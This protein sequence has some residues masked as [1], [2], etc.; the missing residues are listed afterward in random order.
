MATLKTASG[1]I[2][3]SSA[4]VERQAERMFKLSEPRRAHRLEKAKAL[5]ASKAGAEAKDGAGAKGKGGKG[6]GAKGKKKPAKKA[7]ATSVSPAARQAAAIVLG[8]GIA[9]L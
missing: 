2:E 9:E 7:A 3:V 5:L 1:S 8:Q 6:K 4:R